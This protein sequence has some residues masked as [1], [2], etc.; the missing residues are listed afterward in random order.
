MTRQK[1]VVVALLTCGSIV[2]SA[3]AAKA[4]V[5]KCPN[6]GTRVVRRLESG[7]EKIVTYNGT[8]SANPLLCSLTIGGTTGG[9]LLGIFGNTEFGRINADILS[10]LYNG[11]AGAE[12][13]RPV[14]SNGA[15]WNNTYRFE[16]VETIEIGGLNRT[17]RNLSFKQ[18]G[19]EGNVFVGIWHYWLDEASGALLKFTY[20]PVRGEFIAG[21]Y[22]TATSLLVP[23]N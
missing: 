10:R 22:F 4:G 6:P 7:L 14:T 15:I 2:V 13:D 12:I 1:R 9:L 8:P 17:A 19:T 11:D 3:A 16:A 5:F 18:A 21:E 20:Q 23:P